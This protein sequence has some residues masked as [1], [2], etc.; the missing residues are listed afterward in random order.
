MDTAQLV[1]L[2]QLD[3]LT[4]LRRICQK[5]DIPYYLIG[6]TLIGAI[7]HQ[8]FIPW[9][10]D[11]DVGM[12]RRDYD[13]FQQVC[14]QELDPAY[15]LHDWD[16]DPA[17]PHPFLKMKIRGSHYREGLAAQSQM[18]DGIFIDIF[19]Y[20]NAPDRELPL[21]LQA[22]QIY[23]VRK[24]LLLRC[25]FTLDS[26]S[27]LKKL[28]Y[29]TLCTLSKVRSVSAWKKACKKLMLRHNR[30]PTRRVSNMCGSYS[31]KREMMDRTLVQDQVEHVFEKDMFSIPAGY[32]EFL[33]GVY[34]DYMKLPPEDQRVGRHQVI[35]MDLG[36]YQIRSL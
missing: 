31:Y 10:D 24:I 23:L 27:K 16:S 29:G 30:K 22:M 33:R 3:L 2:A 28:L 6:G 18:D 5:H 25:G 15:T 21:R 13:R 11:I 35:Q 7:R 1:K 32:H 20:D 36:G 4:E 19:P 17:S 12:L 26:G 9:D 34:G 14:R 8:G